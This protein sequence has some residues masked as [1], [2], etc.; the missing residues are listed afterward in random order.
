MNIK[1]TLMSICILAANNVLANCTTYE[2]DRIFDKCMEEGDKT[3]SECKRHRDSECGGAH[4]SNTYSGNVG[5]RPY[6]GEYKADPTYRG[7]SFF[8]DKNVKNTTNNWNNNNSANTNHSNNN[9]GWKNIEPHTQSSSRGGWQNIDDNSYSSSQNNNTGSSV[10]D[11]GFPVNNYGQC[12]I[13]ASGQS[14]YVVNHGSSYRT[15]W[16]YIDFTNICDQGF[17]VKGYTSNGKTV[18]QSLPAGRTTR[19]KCNDNK[20]VGSGCNGFSDW[21]K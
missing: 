4:K 10:C 6:V 18:Y 2:R 14:S 16:Y 21:E 20:K 12:C 9:G 8:G 7:S 5:Y 17:A 11:G 15:T 3:R 13:R 1:L 19:L